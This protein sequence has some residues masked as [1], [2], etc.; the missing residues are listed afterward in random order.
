MSIWNHSAHAHFPYDLLQVAKKDIHCFL[1]F[2][3]FGNTVPK[4]EN[5]LREGML[6]AI[7]KH[8]SPQK[9]FIKSV[10]R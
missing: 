1:A 6:K 9:P 4:T 10:T 8:P 3:G 5:A 7:I 2:S